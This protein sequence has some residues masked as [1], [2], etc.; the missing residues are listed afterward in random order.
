MPSLSSRR[1]VVLTSEALF[2]IALGLTSALVIAGLAWWT[3]Q[4]FEGTRRDAEAKV[5]AAALVAKGHAA[6]SIAAIDAVLASVVEVAERDGLDSLRSAAQWQHLRQIARRLPDTGEVFVVDQA[7]T[8][9]AATPTYPA[10]AANIGDREWFQPLMEGHEELH[11]GRAL[12][13][14][15][16][17]HPFFPVARAI[18][19]PDGAF[20]GAV[21]V[22]V[23]VSYLAQL[24]R[25][26]ELGP[27]AEL[28]LYRAGDGAVIARHP[29]TEA[30]LNETVA[31]LPLFSELES[32]P[33]WTGWVERAG[34]DRLAS[35]RRTRGAPI[36]ALVSILKSEVYAGAWTRLLWRGLAASTIWAALLALSA[37][38]IRQAHREGRF[39][40]MLSAS[41]ARFREMAD[42][43][44]VMVWVTEPDGN[45]S[46]ISNSWYEF[47]GQTPETAL[48]RG[49]IDAVHDDDRA[50]I[51][52]TFHSASER[53]AADQAEY[54][55]RRRDGAY[56]WVLAVAAP[57]FGRD[58][59]FLGYIGS[60][61]DISE[62]KEAELALAERN[63]QLALASKAA[64][65]GGY[66]LDVPNNRIQISEGYAA[67]YKLPPGTTEISLD[68]WRAM[69]HSDDVQQLDELRAKSFAARQRERLWRYRIVRRDGQTRWVEA[70]S[71]ISYD[72]AGQPQRV[73]GVNIDVTDQ[74][75]AE[76]R[77]NQLVAELD[78]RVKNVLAKVVVLVERTRESCRSIEEFGEAISGRIRSMANAHTL[79]S[80]NRWQG[81]SLDE[82]ARLELAPYDTGINTTIDG[83]AISLFPEAS[84]AVATVLHELATNAAKYGALSVPDGRVS[85]QWGLADDGAG[86]ARLILRW[87]ETGGPAVTPPTRVGFGT[88]AIRGAI[89]HQLG[90]RVDLTF[91]AGGVCC[92]IEL[93]VSRVSQPR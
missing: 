84:Q 58:G 49:W 59:V 19:G 88:R 47:T 21:Q 64:R 92:K 77:Q 17:D 56:K 45:C 74:Q 29:V 60:V 68:E 48:G 2:K 69:V 53:R 15:S 54:R 50:R 24:L 22:G 11:I 87:Q 61:I 38:A 65:V 43:A 41:E 73:I 82:I 72:G 76:D 32:R 78:H 13:G 44:P 12:K 63:A 3:W 16:V 14:R 18:R 66:I 33:G 7:G 28:G 1:F 89:S 51:T 79:L 71:F 62:R 30:M 90:G 4:D 36:I 80:R 37:L 75:Q 57:H 40:D 91:S 85:L 31:N 6:R 8:L 42:H 34:E 25:D 67:I 9:I 55:L 35:A 46:F 86:P 70:R 81:V 39:R 83:P 5:A 23:E 10:P 27:A 26:L 52:D 20:Q 93:P